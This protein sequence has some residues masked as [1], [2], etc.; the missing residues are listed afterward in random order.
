MKELT[1]KQIK[2]QDFV[3]NAIYHLIQEVNP[4]SETIE[5]DIEMIGD[6]RDVISE[7]L[8]EKMNIA[9]EQT[10]YPYLQE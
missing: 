3:D 7:W 2:R 4:A 9:S 6:V 10:F 5:W 8:V 1:D